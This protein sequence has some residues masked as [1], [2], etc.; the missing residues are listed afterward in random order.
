MKHLLPAIVLFALL[1]PVA[2]AQQRGYPSA[3]PLKS[4]RIA[5]HG[6]VGVLGDDNTRGSSNY[7]YRALFGGE[8]VWTVH[9]HIAV[10][11]HADW[12]DLRSRS[13]NREV[14]TE[15]ADAG[16]LVEFHAPLFKGSLYPFVQLRSGAITILPGV[17]TDGILAEHERSWHLYWSVVA[18]FEIISWRRVGIRSVIGV[19]YSSTDMWDLM[20]QGSDRDGFSFAQIGLSYYIGARGRR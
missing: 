18:G 6:G 13:D 12:G 11:V 10:G 14:N 7:Q 2:S 1:A 4:W 20:V 19:T 16:L 15:F 3:P 8:V 5:F 9:T 17:V